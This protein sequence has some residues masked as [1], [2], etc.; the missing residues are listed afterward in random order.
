MPHPAIV[1]DNVAVITGGA[2]GI[3]FAAAAAF[4]RAGMKV[5]IADVDRERLADA[6]TR[7]S[8]VT[9]ATN[10]MTFAV[11]VSSAESVRELERAVA[12]QFGGTDLLMNNAGIQPGSTLFGE[13]DNWQRVIAVNMWGIINGSRI[14]APNMIA[15]GR[16]GLII[17][18]GSKQGITTPPGDPAYNVSKAGVKAFT[19]ALQHELR[20]TRDCRVTAHLLIPGFVFTGLTAKGRTEKPAGAWTP[21]QTVDFM[22]AR[23]EVGDFYILCPDN[24]VPRALDEKRMQWAAG[25]IVE[26]R[27]P[28]SRWHPDYADA[29]TRFVE[30]K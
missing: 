17:N 21:E 12:A 25:D 30:G 7:L 19:E 23:L 14:F 2:S 22:L 28:L 16:C 20:N 26:N 27:P 3:G 29:F 9:S 8:S 10:V 6:A 1:K 18:T 11:D 13:P 5:C 4:A 15:R 24:D